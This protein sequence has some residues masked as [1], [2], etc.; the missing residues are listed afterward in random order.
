MYCFS[1]CKFENTNLVSQ[2]AIGLDFQAEECADVFAMPIL[3]V[4]HQSVSHLPN[5]V[6]ARDL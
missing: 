5:H 6:Q 1:S 2:R 4:Q 3:C